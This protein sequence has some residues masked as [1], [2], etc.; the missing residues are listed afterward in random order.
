MKCLV[1]KKCSGVLQWASN[2][3]LATKPDRGL[4][5][6]MGAGMILWEHVFQE[7]FWEMCSRSRIFAL[8]C[9][10]SMVVVFI[11]QAKFLTDSSFAL[12]NSGAVPINYGKC[13]RLALHPLVLMPP[14][15]RNPYRCASHGSTGNH[16][17]KGSLRPA[18][19]LVGF[20]WGHC[21]KG[22]ARNKETNL[23][24]R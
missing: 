12:Y 23:P 15:S 16:V 7:N 2:V 5:G 22:R 13:V 6:Y 24:A 21:L 1:N 19:H 8:P 18:S 17:R 14:L 20:S 10:S 4:Y 3:T 9:R 11:S